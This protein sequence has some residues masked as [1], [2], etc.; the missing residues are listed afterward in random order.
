MNEW[1]ASERRP[2]PP[3]AADDNGSACQW[4]LERRSG[5]QSSGSMVRVKDS[6]VGPLPADEVALPSVHGALCIQ[7]IKKY[8]QSQCAV[9]GTYRKSVTVL[10]ESILKSRV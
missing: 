5:S 4:Q 3:A 1:P 9:Y 6:R 2:S 8:Y 7:H 10:K